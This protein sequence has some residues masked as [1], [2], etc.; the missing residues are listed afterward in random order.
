MSLLKKIKDKIKKTTDKDF[1]WPILCL[2]INDRQNIDAAKF[3]GAKR[4]TDPKSKKTVY[5]LENGGEIPIVE[6]KHAIRLESGRDL[7]LVEEVGNGVYTILIKEESKIRGIE[8]GARDYIVKMIRLAEAYKKQVTTFD[9]LMQLAPYAIFAMT[10]VFLIMIV[11]KTMPEVNAGKV[12]MAEGA[13]LWNTTVTLQNEV[14]DKLDA[15]ADKLGQV[16]RSSTDGGDAP[17]W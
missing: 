8:E 4:K 10:I 15:V 1:E 7:L 12:M 3:I 5:E 16:C 17:P 14:A 2:I 11:S 9:K 13:K 6:G